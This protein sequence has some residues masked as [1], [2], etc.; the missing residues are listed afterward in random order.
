MKT[1]TTLLLIFTLNTAIFAGAKMSIHLEENGATKTV[2]FQC[3]DLS[4]C[5]QRIQ[6][7]MEEEGGC[8]PRVKKVVL[9]S[10]YIP[11][12]DDA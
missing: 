4:E 2:I 7:R 12:L 3:E 5:A 9:E 10:I 6:T 8:D 11:G 1:L